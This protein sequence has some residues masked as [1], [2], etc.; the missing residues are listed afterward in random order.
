MA[1][2][3]APIVSSIADPEEGLRVVS[4][5]AL[6]QL[7]L[8]DY[9]QWVRRIA[10][11]GTSCGRSV[12][13]GRVDLTRTS[14]PVTGAR[15]GYTSVLSSLPATGPVHSRPVPLFRRA[16]SENLTGA[17]GDGSG[18]RET[19]YMVSGG[20][21]IC[22]GTGG[23]GGIHLGIDG[24]NSPVDFVSDVEFDVSPRHRAGVARFSCR[25]LTPVVEPFTGERMGVCCGLWVVM[26]STHEVTVLCRTVGHATGKGSHT[27]VIG[28]DRISTVA[29][30][31]CARYMECVV[32]LAVSSAQ[33][34]SMGEKSV[35]VSNVRRL[36]GGK[37][38]SRMTM[39]V[40]DVED[41]ESKLLGESTAMLNGADVYIP[42]GVKGLGLLGATLVDVFRGRV[43]IAQ[44]D[45]MEGGNGGDG[46]DGNSA[47]E[48][49]GDTVELELDGEPSTD[50]TQLEEGIKS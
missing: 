26:G 47:V 5:L 17:N 35:S 39:V 43:R 18:V 45:C 37:F 2:H 30:R 6:I 48:D 36:V 44:A 4:G 33:I 13:D 1:G 11:C 15:T 25:T 42:S 23:T 34:E 19:S 32:Y 12:F 31:L 38:H 8:A 3:R 41:N 16:P 20:R 28:M 29:G 46:G 9:L 40:V 27:T 49:M 50:E 21:L 22:S 14:C 24:L 7:H 10:K